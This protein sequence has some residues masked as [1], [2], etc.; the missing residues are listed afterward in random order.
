ML[1]AFMSEQIEFDQI[2]Q[3][4]WSVPAVESAL[5]GFGTARKL[6]E[7]TNWSGMN[8]AFCCFFS[9]RVM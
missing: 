6:E 4:E 9:F 5:T 1:V 3:V 8:L 7:L 2:L